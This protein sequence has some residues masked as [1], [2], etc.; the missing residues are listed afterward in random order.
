MEPFR[1]PDDASIRRLLG[2]VHRI[3]VVGLSPKAYR[4]YWAASTT[5]ARGGRRTPGWRW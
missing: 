1:N 4:D 3:A 5:A 2:T